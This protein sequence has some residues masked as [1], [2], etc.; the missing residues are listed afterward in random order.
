MSD[1]F[2]ETY[3]DA[4]NLLC[5]ELLGEGIHRKVFACRI[6]RD[7]VVKVEDDTKVNRSFANAFESRFWGDYQHAPA[8]AKWLAPVEYMSP[9]GR[10][11]LQTRAE[12]I[13]W[14]F[15]LPDKLPGFLTDVKRENFGLIEGRLVCLDYSSTVLDAGTRLKKAYW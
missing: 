2:K 9:D 1:F 13:P 4:F 15:H 11:L 12:P 10:I 3:E 14:D 5:G 8:V 7:L 6:R